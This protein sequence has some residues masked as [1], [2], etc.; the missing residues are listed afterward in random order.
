[1]LVSDEEKV[2]DGGGIED[3]NIQVMEMSVE[4]ARR[5]LWVRDEDCSE[6]RPAAMLFALSWFFYQYQGPK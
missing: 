3:E 2:A 4:E 6:S 5:L 1:M